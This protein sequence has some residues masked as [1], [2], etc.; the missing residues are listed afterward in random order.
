MRKSGLRGRGGALGWLPMA[1]TSRTISFQVAVLDAAVRAAESEGESLSGYV[2][3][4]VIQRLRAE[5]RWTE[6]PS[7][8]G[9]LINRARADGVDVTALIRS[10]L[11][12]GDQ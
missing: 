12:G 7:H 6:G 4:A 5:G 10:S 1:T 8:L 2:S 11:E 3:G 9:E